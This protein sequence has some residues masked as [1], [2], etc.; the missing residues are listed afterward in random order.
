[1]TD[2][3]ENLLTAY[4]AMLD[5]LAL[6]NTIWT[7]DTV[8]AASVSDLEL[9]VFEI[10][11]QKDKQ[12][13][14]IKGYA[15][16]KKNK[17]SEL[18][19]SLMFIV[20]R[21]QSYAAASESEGLLDNLQ[22]SFGKLYKMRDTALGGFVNDVLLRA[23]E[24]LPELATYGINAGTLTNL[25][26]LYASYVELLS[27]PRVA[28]SE[29][30]IATDRLKILFNEGSKILSLRLD[31]DIQVFEEPNPDF[32]DG[33]WNVREIVDNTGRKIQIRGTVKDLLT[34]GPIKGVTLKLLGFDNT[35]KTSK[36]GGFSLKGLEPMSYELEI[37]KTG[38]KS[39]VLNNIKVE[40]DKLTKIN[41]LLEKENSLSTFQTGNVLS[42]LSGATANQI[43]APSGG[44]LLNKLLK[45]TV[46][47][48]GPIK[49]S[50]SKIAGVHNSL[51]SLMMNPGEQKT[52]A[53]TEI[54][55]PGSTNLV[56]TNYGSIPASV[57]VQP[58]ILELLR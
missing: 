56:I 50:A 36:T 19:T 57:S 9:K 18:A 39:K 7:I 49:V 58:G 3:Q 33:Y 53:M 6:N 28:I 26:T 38:Y 1:M 24:L 44:T 31:K 48:G 45:L 11:A 52:I 30:K 40:A 35:V 51:L 41:I 20:G 22:Y 10:N 8:F 5:Y 43:V 23:N 25:E 34:S 42:I 32:Y 27:K 54:G 14:A 21:M 4:K 2:R 17:K 29:R 47:A 37:L 55:E 46:T 13:I 12:M 15:T 16:N